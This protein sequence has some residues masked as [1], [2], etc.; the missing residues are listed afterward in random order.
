[1]SSAVFVFRI[2][3]LVLIASSFLF[4]LCSCSSTATSAPTGPS[5]KRKNAP[6]AE[7][8]QVALR[9]PSTPRQ[10]AS[11]DE[12]AELV[13]DSNGLSSLSAAANWSA[14]KR[15][16]GGGGGQFEAAE[17]CFLANGGSSLTLAV[18]EATQVGAIVGTVDV[19]IPATTC[20]N[21]R[22]RAANWAASVARARR[23]GGRKGE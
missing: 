20:A 21:C 12:S 1:M 3:F 7:A 2:L 18:N 10:E 14:S 11:L 16:E 19:S 17:L 8:E 5:N 22:A 23:P 4:L 9:R 6:A 15:D 13:A